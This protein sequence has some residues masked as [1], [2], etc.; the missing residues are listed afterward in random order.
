MIPY[1]RFTTRPEIRGSFG[2]AASTHWIA[3]SAAMGVLER[4]GNAFDAAVA[5]GF[6]LQVVEPHL[7]GPGGEVPI[8]LWSEKEQ[9]MRVVCGQGVAPQAASAGFFRGLGLNQ[10]PGT[11]LLAATV[12]GA[13]DAWM[14]LLRDHGTISLRKALEPALHYAEYGYPLVPRICAAIEAVKSL[15]LEEW[16]SSA[17]IYM[18]GGRTPSPFDQLRN[19]RHAATYRRVLREAEAAGA[20]R[21]RQIEAA[22][23][24]WYRGFVADAIDR[25]CRGTEVIDT[26]GERHR[27]LLTSADMARWQAEYDEPLVYEYH[28]YTVAKCG[29]WSQGPALLQQLAILRNF[30]IAGMDPLGAEFVHTVAEAA[31]LA[32][33]DR[34]A[35]Y[36]DPR[37]AD[38]PLAALLSDGYAA[39]RARLIAPQASTAFR[40]GSPEGRKPLFPDYQAAIRDLRKDS[41]FYGIGEPTFAELDKSTWVHESGYAR[42]DTCHVDVIDRWGNM[43]S[44]TPSGGWLSSSPVMPELGFPLNTR[45]QVFWLDEGHP[46]QLAPGKRPRTSL[47]P[48]M[49]LKKGEPWAAFGTPGGDQQDQWQAILFLRLAHHGMNLQEAI[50]SPSW[51]SNHML[52]SFWPR[53]PHLGLLTLEGRFDPAVAA[54]LQRRGHK[55]ALGEDWSEGRLSICTRERGTHGLLLKAGANARGMQGYAVGR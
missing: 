34:E 11:G 42:G 4:G 44:A 33:A 22:R 36:G 17:A 5:A 10:V 37:Y 49:A 29:A 3:S 38:V 20:G 47:S 8:L 50:D 32:F 40:P 25:Y 43:V 26:T 31:K 13:F 6:V 41:Y 28:G 12:P 51:H 45:L 30:D 54:E 2:V 35:W 27:G 39:G 46:N 55:V 48:S 7:N 18:P 21:V 52:A 1:T 24:T 53:Q 23:N 9:R 19:P 16:Q 14:L 15:F